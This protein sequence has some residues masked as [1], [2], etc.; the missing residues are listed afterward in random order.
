MIFLLFLQASN[1][2]ICIYRVDICTRH[3]SWIFLATVKVYRGILGLVLSHWLIA[4]VNRWFVIYET[5]SNDIVS[6][7]SGHGHPRLS[8]LLVEPVG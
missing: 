7:F 4:T 5:V 2:R 6:S 8:I 1:N 3:S